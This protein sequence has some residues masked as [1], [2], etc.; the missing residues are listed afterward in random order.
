MLSL[1]LAAEGRLIGALNLYALE[2]DAFDAESVSVGEVLAAHT[3][4][5]TQVASAFFGH[6]ELA[7][8][9][10][11]AMESRAVIEQAKGVVMSATGA[12]AEKAFDLLRTA[13]QHRNVKLRDLAQQVVDTR[14]ADVLD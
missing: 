6:R 5:A 10:R 13:S 4:L 11:V 9:M 2:V 14:S 1:P 12:D 3:G 8:Q 7:D